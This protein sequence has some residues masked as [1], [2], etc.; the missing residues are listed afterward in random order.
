MG[1]MTSALIESTR[2]DRG[3]LLGQYPRVRP[4]ISTSGRKLACRADVEVGATT[5]G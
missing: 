3:G 1:E 2:I 5:S 4:A